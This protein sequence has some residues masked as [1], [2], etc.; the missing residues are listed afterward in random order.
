MPNL[1]GMFC[2]TKSPER[3]AL[4]RFPWEN[5]GYGQGRFVGNGRSQLPP[6]THLKKT[7]AASQIKI[8][9]IGTGKTDEPAATEPTRWLDLSPR[10]F[11]DNAIESDTPSVAS[12]PKRPLSNSHTRQTLGGFFVLELMANFLLPVILEL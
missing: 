5:G 3:R 2:G 7:P 4:P 1:T 8:Q 9:I 12:H 11:I 6:L 10:R